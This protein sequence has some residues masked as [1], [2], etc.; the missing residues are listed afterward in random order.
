MADT[1]HDFAAH[2][3]GASSDDLE[4][5]T[6]ANAKSFIVDTL[7][8]GI[9]GSG[10]PMVPELIGTLAKTVS[11]DEARVWATG[12]LTLDVCGQLMVRQLRVGLALACSILISIPLKLLSL[13]PFQH[14]IAPAF[15]IPFGSSRLLPAASTLPNCAD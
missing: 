13:K 9:G 2:V 5:Q 1:I 4:A 15:L 6:V 12:L 10:G 8:V 3:A 7:G 11:G 14:T